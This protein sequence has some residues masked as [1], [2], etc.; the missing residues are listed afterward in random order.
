MIN[1]CRLCDFYDLRL[2][3][4]L[5]TSRLTVETFGRMAYGR[6]ELNP[7]GTC[8]LFAPDP[9]HL[10]QKEQVTGWKRLFRRR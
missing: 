6:D 2:G 1:D 8:I 7:R 5:H 9:L 10:T 4:C 3:V